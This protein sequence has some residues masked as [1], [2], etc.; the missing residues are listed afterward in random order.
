[1]LSHGE[2]DDDF[3]DELTDILISC[4]IGV[5]TSMDIVDNLRV[6]ARKNKLRNADDVKRIER[7]IKRRILIF[8]TT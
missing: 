1:M 5:R 6:R 2:L 4:D 3:Y 8:R 7:N